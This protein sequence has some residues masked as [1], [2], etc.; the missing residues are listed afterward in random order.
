MTNARHTTDRAKVQ[1]P[2]DHSHVLLTEQDVFETWPP[3]LE[4]A[5]AWRDACGD[6][7]DNVEAAGGDRDA[8][9]AFLLDYNAAAKWAADVALNPFRAEPPSGGDTLLFDDLF[10]DYLRKDE[11]LKELDEAALA[12]LSVTGEPTVCTWRQWVDAEVEV[13]ALKR[14]YEIVLD[15]MPDSWPSDKHGQPKVINGQTKPGH[16]RRPVFYESD[17]LLQ[18]LLAPPESKP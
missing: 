10:R 15:R 18:P 1:A 16:K 6:A 7:M 11:A 8:I 5:R 14:K 13:W 12:M 17:R 3:E 4:R 9:D 2:D